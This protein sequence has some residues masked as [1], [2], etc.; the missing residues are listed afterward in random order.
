MRSEIFVG[1]VRLLLACAG[2]YFAVRLMIRAM[3]PNKEQKEKSKKKAEELMKIIELPEDIELDEYEMRIAA[4]LVP[5]SNGI[6][7][8][9]IGGLY[10]VIE[11]I[12]G[13]LLLPLQMMHMKQTPL[14]SSLLSPSKGVLLFGPPGCG[15]TM[16]AKAIAKS[17]HA[18]FIHLDISVLTDKWY[19]ES[20]KLVSALFSFAE[21]VQPCVIFIDEIDGFLRNRSD[22]DNE[23][24]A[25]IKTQFMALWDG[26]ASGN[27]EII[28]MGATN[29]PLSLDPA[30]FRRMPARFEVPYPDEK[31]RAKIFEIY[32]K[33][34]KCPDVNYPQLA[35]FS[36]RLS[37]SDIKEVCRA[38]ALSALNRAYNGNSSLHEADFNIFQSDLLRSLNVCYGGKF[39]SCVSE[40]VNDTVNEMFDGKITYESLD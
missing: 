21:K 19:G 23:T 39:P 1:V 11:D 25:L 12:R 2:S 40:H 33:S 38:A 27:N 28:I 8:S 17:I 32:L 37:G 3:D 36:P 18:R 7:W 9:D 31:S 14:V 10:K 24:T 35:K 15:K 16:I 5:E 13:A 29:N 26:F 22:L 6:D 20:Q 4:M 30:I 34:E